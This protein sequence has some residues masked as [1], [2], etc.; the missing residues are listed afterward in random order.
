MTT[1]IV[2]PNEIPTAGFK[3]FLAG[4]IDMGQAVDWQSYVIEK[5]GGIDDL[6]LVNPRRPNF[7]PD[8]LDEQILWELDAL[9]TASRIFMWFPKNAKA[10]ISFFESGLYMN[11]RKLIIG[12]EDGFYRRRNLEL[13]T[14]H[15]GVH[16]FNNLDAMMN[17]LLGVGYL[18]LKRTVE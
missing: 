7:T 1:T 4:A 18:N 9:D 3:V 10:P 5:L 8:T 11:S 13:T 15:Y 16:L 14:V 17:E 12:A 6:V 2:A